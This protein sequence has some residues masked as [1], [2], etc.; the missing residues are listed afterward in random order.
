M[1]AGREAQRQRKGMRDEGEQGVDG[2]LDGWQR[3][4]GGGG[5]FLAQHFPAQTTSTH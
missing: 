4:G 2:W 5:S 3:E 1:S